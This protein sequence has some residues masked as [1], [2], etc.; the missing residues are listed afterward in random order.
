V[1]GGHGQLRR[2][3]RERG[4]ALRSGALQSGYSTGWWCVGVAMAVSLMALVLLLDEGIA[5]LQKARCVTKLFGLRMQ[6]LHMRKKK[7]ANQFEPHQSNY[8][9]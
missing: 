5:E 1:C 8:T 3:R 6:T 7:S 9:C 4:R 2:R